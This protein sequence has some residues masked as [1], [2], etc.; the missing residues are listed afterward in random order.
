MFEEH[1]KDG[2]FAGEK[3]RN[4]RLIGVRVGIFL[5]ICVIS[6]IAAGYMKWSKASLHDQLMKR[7]EETTAYYDRNFYKSDKGVN[8]IYSI[9]YTFTVNGKHYHNYS[10]SKTIPTSSEG[11][12]YYNPNDPEENELQ[13]F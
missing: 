2:S 3:S 6:L 12:V 1:Y 8:A 13:P 9:G 11:I 4:I 10:Q 7:H 5:A